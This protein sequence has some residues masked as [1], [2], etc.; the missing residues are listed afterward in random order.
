MV[1]GFCIV[2]CL[3]TGNF[4]TSMQH[5]YVMGRH[6][7]AVFR[8]SFDLSWSRQQ[9]SIYT[10]IYPYLICTLFTLRDSYNHACYCGPIANEK[11]FNQVGDMT[12][13]CDN[14]LILFDFP[15]LP[16]GLRLWRVKSS[17]WRIQKAFV[18]S[19]H[20][21]CKQ[22]P[23]CSQD[24]TAWWQFVNRNYHYRIISMV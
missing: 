8:L 11:A 22:S 7:V 5:K 3:P 21:R 16:A 10:R 15:L 17:T 14:H 20:T 9:S 18:Q 2:N 12:L 23:Y 24:N 4:T 19:V 6:T 1:P 13:V